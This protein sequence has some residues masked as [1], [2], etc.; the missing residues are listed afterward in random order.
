MSSMS[1]NTQKCPSCTESVPLEYSVCPFCGFGLLEYEL[2]K[3]AFRPSL[4]EVFIRLYLFFRKPFKTSEELGVATETKGANI[5]LLLFSLFLSLRFY[6]VMVKAG[7]T[8]SS[9]IIG[10]PDPEAWSM[11]VSLNLIF[12]FVSLLLMPF[13]I[14]IMYKLLFS[15]GTWIM[16][17]FAAMLGSEATTK[18]YRTIIGYSIAPIVVGEFLGM[19]FTLMGTPGDIGAPGAVGFDTFR[20]FVE[21]LYNSTPMLIFKILMIILWVVV[22]I[23]SSIALRVVG[24]MA[25]VNAFASITIP[26]ALFVYF[27]YF[28]GLFG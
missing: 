27:F 5:I 11:E 14:W 23:Y 4:K 22:I 19:F 24:K 17:K 18:Q 12:F 20:L 1:E 7:I 25:W 15:I 3:F 28:I 21:D 9:L 6:F 13:V 2:K 8:F 16:A 10:N 26:V